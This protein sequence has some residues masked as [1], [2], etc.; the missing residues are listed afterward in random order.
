[1]PLEKN[2]ALCCYVGPD[3]DGERAVEYTFYGQNYIM[4]KL[5]NTVR[6]EDKE[7]K[8]DENS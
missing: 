3:K 5:K 7:V 8:S 6:Y 1:M 4:T 2:Q